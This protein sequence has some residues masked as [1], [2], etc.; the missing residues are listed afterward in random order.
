[1]QERIGFER[2]ISTLLGEGRRG[3]VRQYDISAQVSH[4]QTIGFEFDVHYGFVEEVITNAGRPSPADGDVV[5]THT[6]G[7]DFFKVKR[8]GPR[9][10]I[11]TKP[12]TTDKP[13]GAEIEKCLTNI[14]K[15]VEALK[16]G[17][18]NAKEKSITVA[19]VTGKPHPF[20]LPF[21]LDPLLPIVKL[22]LGGKFDRDCRVWASPQATITLPIWKVSSLVTEIRNSQGK[23]VGVAL[24]GNND[25]RMGVR[26]E[27]I[28]RAQAAVVAVKKKLIK[29]NLLVKALGNKPL[30]DK[31]FSDRLSGFLI[32]LASYLITSELPYRF[33]DTAP[34]RLRD[35]EPFAK[36][37][38]P[39]N[40]KA[41]F[42][43]IFA[44]LLFPEDQ[45]IFREVFADG[46]ARKRLFSLARPGAGLAD[47]SRK[48]FPTGPKELGN[49]SVHVRQALEFGSAPTWD[50]LVEHTLDQSHKTWGSR[51]LVP[52]SHQIPLDKTR[53][54]FAVEMRRIGWTSVFSS[55]WPGLVARVLKLARKLNN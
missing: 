17:C 53:P 26:S 52:I 9:L 35:Y 2:E 25:Q 1:M 55:Q 51:L 14:G 41:P 31:T 18:A 5:T 10:E 15:F 34:K 30:D 28:Y 19:G 54:R 42:P 24:T 49:D 33:E 45:F 3:P 20:P 11:A 47:G 6:W 4:P 22:P 29:D 38:L 16:K 27:A 7:T 32:L 37:Y 46:A 12:F 13:G 40:V 43:D 50:D 39:L 48:L 23:G 44:E 8:D 21:A 36:A